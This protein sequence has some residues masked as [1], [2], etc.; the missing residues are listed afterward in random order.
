MKLVLV[1]D[2]NSFESEKYRMKVNEGS[3][4][5]DPTFVKEG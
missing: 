3:S 1:R 5:W 2:G 4:D